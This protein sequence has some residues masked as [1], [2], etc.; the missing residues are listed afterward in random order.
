MSN[1]CD[2]SFCSKKAKFKCTCADKPKLCVRHY[3]YHFSY[4]Q[5]HAIPIRAFIKFRTSTL[6][7]I[8]E[9]EDIKHKVIAQTHEIIMTITKISENILFPLDEN[10]RNLKKSLK[11]KKPS[12]EH[13]EIISNAKNITFHKPDLNIFI[14]YSENLMSFNLPNKEISIFK[15]HN[16]EI[17]RL[18]GDVSNEKFK[19]RDL[20]VQIDEILAKYLQ[21]EKELIGLKNKHEKQVNS[22]EKEINEIQERNSSEF[23]INKQI[24]SDLEIKINEVEHLFQS[25]LAEKER[26]SRRM[27]KNLKKDFA[28]KSRASPTFKIQH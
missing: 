15:A 10:I 24:R 11:E 14:E 23:T 28:N 8:K 17:M 13:K 22:L 20:E 6:E 2:E 7:G 9:L 25:V 21:T 5:N 3:D 12:T 16:D 4:C 26:K 19:F 18:Q 1:N 27:I